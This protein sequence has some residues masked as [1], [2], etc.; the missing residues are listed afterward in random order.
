MDV[1]AP[2]H[3]PGSDD[4]QESTH[5]TM[6]GF[7]PQPKVRTERR[8]DSGQ[9]TLTFP[10]VSVPIMISN[11]FLSEYI[12]RDLRIIVEKG[13]F[14]GD[15]GNNALGHLNTLLLKIIL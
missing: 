4:T 11:L 6:E 14:K 5:R 1:I 12:F 9:H 8:K 3:Y 13:S 7:P 2:L 10:A 15:T